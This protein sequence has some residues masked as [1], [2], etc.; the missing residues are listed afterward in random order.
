MGSTTSTQ[1][2]GPII[3]LLA[4]LTGGIVDATIIWIPM[5]VAVTIV[6]MNLAIKFVVLGWGVTASLLTLLR[7]L[8]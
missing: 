5:I 8:Q 2:V 6:G 1:K 4:K 7:I 3:K